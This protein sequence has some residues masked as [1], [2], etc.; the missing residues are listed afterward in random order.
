[1][2]TAMDS[3]PTSGDEPQDTAN[4]QPERA[5]YF[6]NEWRSRPL[7]RSWTRPDGERGPLLTDAAYDVLE[8]NHVAANNL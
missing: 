2:K 3:H 4:A 8:A 6:D 1:M 7:W 5:R